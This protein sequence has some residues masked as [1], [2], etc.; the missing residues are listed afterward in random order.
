MFFFLVLFLFFKMSREHLFNLTLTMHSL[1]QKG[2]V[3][4]DTQNFKRA[5]LDS[6]V[7][8]DLASTNPFF[9]VNIHA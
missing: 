1:V 4:K 7:L 8:F 5:E 2:R 3:F 9:S 6:I